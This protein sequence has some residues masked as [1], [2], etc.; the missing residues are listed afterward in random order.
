VLAGVAWRSAA[1]ATGM[2][3]AKASKAGELK[4]G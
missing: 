1:I 2:A 4:K 3:R